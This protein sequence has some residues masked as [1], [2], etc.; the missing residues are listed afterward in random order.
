MGT[1]DRKEREREEHK[2]LI[3]NAS[4]QIM[5]SEG[6]D[7]LSIRKIAKKIEYSPAIIYHYF[8]D[9]DEI[10]NSLMTKGYKRILSTLA[11]INSSDKNPKEKLE[12]GFKNYIFASLNDPLE[13]KTILLSSSPSILEHTSVLFKGAAQ[14]REAIGILVQILRDIYRES[15]K[16]ESYIEL[17]AQVLWSSVFGLI[18]RMITEENLTEDQKNKLVEHQLSILIKGI[19]P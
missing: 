5:I 4:E 3:L 16:D 13:Y 12:E 7:N 10:I 19:M 6:L 1:K 8:K 17:I 14:K 18:I 15:P 9:K 2:E 11:S